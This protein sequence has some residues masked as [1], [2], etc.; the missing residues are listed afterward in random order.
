MYAGN[1]ESTTAMASDWSESCF[2]KSV[3]APNCWNL[4]GFWEL[5]GPKASMG[6]LDSQKKLFFYFVFQMSPAQPDFFFFF[7]FKDILKKNL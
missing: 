3:V 5:L 6:Q 2:H 4:A 1:T 7:F